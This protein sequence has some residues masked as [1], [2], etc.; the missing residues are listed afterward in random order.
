MNVIPIF[1]ILMMKPYSGLIVEAVLAH[2]AICVLV[3]SDLVA[4]Y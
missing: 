1:N 4:S 3:M 2:S